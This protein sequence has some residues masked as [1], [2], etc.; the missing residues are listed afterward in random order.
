MGGTTGE[1]VD[2]VI[3]GVARRKCSAFGSE[4]KLLRSQNSKKAKS[5]K[6]PHPIPQEMP[7]ALVELM[8]GIHAHA[9]ILELREV[10]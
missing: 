10:C 2:D 7:A 1:S 3:N 5:L 6:R 4:R 8:Q 9:F